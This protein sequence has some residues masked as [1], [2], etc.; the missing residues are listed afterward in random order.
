Q[1]SAVRTLA[2][3]HACCAV[4]TLGARGALACAGAAV[5]ASPA[6]RPP[7]LEDTTG[8]GDAFRAGFIYGLAHGLP[9]E[10]TLRAANAAASLSCRAMGARA[11]MPDEAELRAFLAMA[12]PLDG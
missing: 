1:E 4:V 9:L 2:E 10:E 5:I 12:S 3:R 8:A 6:L 11:A 7:R